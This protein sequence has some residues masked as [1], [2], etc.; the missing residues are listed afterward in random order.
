MNND[1]DFIKELFK[2]AG[3]TKEDMLLK[4]VRGLITK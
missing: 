1:F 3:P 4:Y 2:V